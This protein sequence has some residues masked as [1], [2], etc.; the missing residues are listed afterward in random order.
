[1]YNSNGIIVQV[2][3]FPSSFMTY[4]EYQHL[5]LF[6]EKLKLK[7]INIR[8]LAYTCPISASSRSPSVSRSK[9]TS[10]QNGKALKK[11]AGTSARYPE[12]S[13]PLNSHFPFKLVPNNPKRKEHRDPHRASTLK[14]HSQSSGGH[15]PSM[16]HH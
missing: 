7:F 16:S 4:S 11:D 12:S 14:Y 6:L 8:L 2:M 15:A 13:P 10:V 1:M 3:N 9:A 5:K